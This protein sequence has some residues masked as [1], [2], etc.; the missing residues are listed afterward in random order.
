VIDTSVELAGL[1]L[2]NPLLPGSGPPGATLRKLRK[3][4]LAGI[5]AMLAKTISTVPAV[6]PKPCMAFD[7][8]LFF[9]IEK[10]S[11]ISAAEWI[12]EI[13]PALKERE[14]PLLV[15]VG[16]TAKDVEALFP[17]LDEWVDGYELSTHYGTSRQEQYKAIVGTAKKLTRKPVIMKLS[18]HAPDL[19]E[20]AKTCEASG[21]DAITAINSIGPV[22]S[23]DIEKR[24]SRLG[25]TEPYA[26]LSGPAIKPLAMRAVYDI[27]HTVKIP[28]IACGGVASGRDV[29]E[30]MMAGATAVE[31]CTTLIRKGPVWIAE[32]VKEITDWCEAHDVTTLKELIGTVTP[33]YTSSHEHN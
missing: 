5:G 28:V 4:E 12:S 13:L 1:H 7:G 2:R 27:A 11:E 25:V 23:I 15:S 14:V 9:N 16:Y 8:E 10:W 26:W 20:T 33:H 24:S 21:A 6:V 19:L 18:A 30:F 32:T 3:L 22:M 17:M 29:I 31:S